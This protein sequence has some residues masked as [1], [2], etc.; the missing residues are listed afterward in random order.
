ML[1]TLIAVEVFA[2]TE[3]AMAIAAI[4][5]FMRVFE[6]DAAA[7]GWT[8][9]AYL[10]VGAGFA[11]TS[12]RLG[13]IFGRRNVLVF[14]LGA[15]ACGSLISVLATDLWMVVLGRGIQGLA[16]GALPI[17]F[18][19]VRELL[20][21][22]R[23]PL[24]IALLGGIVPICAGAGGLLAGVLLDNGGWRLLFSVATVLGIAAALTGLAGLPRTPG[25]RPRPPVDMVGAALLLPA[26]GGVLFGVT[27]AGE[28]GWTDMWV[29]ASIAAGIVALAAWFGWERRVREPIVDVRQFRNRKVLLTTLGTLAVGMGGQ[30]AATIM[31]PIVLQLPDSAPV[32]MGLSPTAAGAVMLCIAVISY[33]GAALSGRIAQVA[34]ARWSLMIACALYIVGPVIWILQA[35]SLVGTLIGLGLTNIGSAFAFTALPNLIVEVVP[36][37][38]TGAAT[39][40]NRVTLNVSIATGLAIAS[41]ILASSTAP[42]TPFP[43]EAALTGGCLF[44][45]GSAV[46]TLILTAF[47]GGARQADARQAPT[48]DLG[49]KQAMA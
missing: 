39:G 36:P 13:D 4:P 11:A 17:S 24:A 49:S 38:Q 47:I 18:A 6:A 25:L 34:G 37:E 22:R 8:T 33:G 46:V 31:A 32:G 19:L 9:T 44:I 40:M 16:A 21:E 48:P 20:P 7:V 41:V 27:Q 45:I 23:V 5:T 43:T 15:A 42:G 26:S 1:L 10:L 2:V 12:G 14:L 28:W 30:G 29:L 35:Q 3:T